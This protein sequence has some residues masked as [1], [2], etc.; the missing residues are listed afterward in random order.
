MNDRIADWWYYLGTAEIDAGGP[1]GSRV[2]AAHEVFA[3]LGP[4]ANPAIPQLLELA[5][6]GEVPA[7]YV[8]EDIRPQGELALIDAFA[9]GKLA[10]RA[11]AVIWFGSCK[12]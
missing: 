6:K 4:S 11:N 9:K 2:S 12:E 8:L 3:I 5:A 10:E 1:I 7:Q